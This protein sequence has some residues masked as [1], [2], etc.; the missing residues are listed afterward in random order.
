M[1]ALIVLMFCLLQ[2]APG[3]AR[4]DD[5]VD[6]FFPETLKHLQ[7]SQSAYSVFWWNFV[8]VPP[9]TEGPDFDKADAACE[10]V[11]TE[12]NLRWIACGENVLQMSEALGDWA[13]DVVYREPFSDAVAWKNTLEGAL[14]EAG[15][16]ASV[17][18][19]LFE[20]IRRDPGAEWEKYLDKNPIARTSGFKRDRGFLVDAN[21]NRIVIPL[22]FQVRPKMTNAEGV[23]NA[24]AM[25]PGVVLVGPHAASFTNEK[26]VHDDMSSVSVVGLVVL[27]LFILGM[28][29]SGRS[30]ALWIVPPVSIAL[31]ASAGLTILIYGS[32]HGLTLAFGSAIVGL[33]ADYGLHGAFSKAQSTWK[34]NAIGFLTT[35][36]GLVV[37]FFSQI[38]LIRQMMFFSATGILVGFI[39]FFLLCRKFPKHFTIRSFDFQFPSFR[40]SWILIALLVG[41]GGWGT[42]GL[43]LSFDLR[44]FNY[45]PAEQAELLNWFFSRGG[46]KD[47]FI[48]LKDSAEFEKNDFAE[49]AWAK[50]H[51]IDLVSLANYTV[52]AAERRKNAASWNQGCLYARGQFSKESQKIFAPFVENI[53]RAQIP[54]IGFAEF[55][56]RSYANH[57]IHEN[58]YVAILSAANAEQATLIRERFPQARSIAESVRGFSDALNS[59]LKW[60]IPLAFA[61]SLLVLAIYYRRAFFVFTSVLPF[62]SGMGLFSLAGI[63]FEANLNLISVLGLLMV[64]GFSIDY[65][66]FAT[67]TVFY[68]GHEN[69]D[70][71][72]YS[73]LGI[74]AMT[75]II[76]FLPLLFARHPV[77]YQ[78]GFA[79]FFGTVGTYLGT[80][81]GAK[82]LL[83]MWRKRTSCV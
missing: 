59:D 4:I 42:L 53:C 23:M 66:V 6:I 9:T 27:G 51:K 35:L 77:L 26:Q 39:L 21:T 78:M 32:I 43:D 10:S 68:G 5:S 16:M 37:L 70:R 31:A 55:A 52:P 74:A 29:V 7:K 12:P 57:L 73:A 44:R 36:V 8:I 15:L 65:G 30:A 14:S 50:D 81:W 48:D 71:V 24:L 11:A 46:Q 13:D 62:L 75:N 54:E 41:L 79:L 17:N 82:P 83:E 1:R 72:V 3:F 61:V 64:F 2:A 63:F 20:H 38:P 40:G 49:V 25:V 45:Q 22:Q 19:K 76:G 58:G 56:Q 80:V 33:V 34:S 18:R 47:L 67:D 28:C 69:E 60:M